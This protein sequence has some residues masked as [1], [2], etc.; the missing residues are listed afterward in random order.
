MDTIVPLGIDST[1]METFGTSTRNCLMPSMPVPRSSVGAPTS[2]L[3][4]VINNSG[5]GRYSEAAVV[6]SSSN[7]HLAAA[8]R[9]EPHKTLERRHRALK[10]DVAF[11]LH[12]SALGA[13]WIL[14]VPVAVT[15]LAERGP[16]QNRS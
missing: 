8:I 12:L 9:R 11:A 14:V 7:A 10:L 3:C 6:G 4:P 1:E 5:N 2:P 13:P 15:L 16:S